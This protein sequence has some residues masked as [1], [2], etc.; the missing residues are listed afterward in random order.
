[1]FEKEVCED[2]DNVF[3]IITFSFYRGDFFGTPS[4]V[5]RWR[6][7]FLLISP[8]LCVCTQVS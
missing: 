1:M 2:E 5:P 8:W 4:K 7:I 3:L 6:T